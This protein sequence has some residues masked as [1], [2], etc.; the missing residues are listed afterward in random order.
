MP[1]PPLAG[2]HLDSDSPSFSLLVPPALRLH[3]PRVK[4]QITDEE[5]DPLGVVAISVTPSTAAASIPA[6]IAV[7]PTAT[8][9]ATVMVV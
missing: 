8:A 5:G 1:S 2:K 3:S 7:A 9:S 6:A 4:G